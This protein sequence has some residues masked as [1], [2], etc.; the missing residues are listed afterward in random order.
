MF[1]FHSPMS[2]PMENLWAFFWFVFYQAAN[3][4]ARSNLGREAQVVGNSA[5]DRER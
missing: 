3:M 1:E 5:D 4:L 2:M